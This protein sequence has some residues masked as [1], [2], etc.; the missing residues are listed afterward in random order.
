[1]PQKF[2]LEITLG[3]DAMKTNFD[4]GAKLMGIGNKITY[5]GREMI[6]PGMNETIRDSNGNV[7]GHYEVV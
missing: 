2:V 6:E 5:G 4:L 1:M 7:V 3:N